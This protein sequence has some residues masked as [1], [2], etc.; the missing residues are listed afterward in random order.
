M[1]RSLLSHI[2]GTANLDNQA[3]AGR[4]NHF[5]LVNFLA[6][7]DAASFPPDAWRESYRDL[8]LNTPDERPYPIP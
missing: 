3:V 6:P 1:C 7:R 4:L 8:A 5:D 2:Q